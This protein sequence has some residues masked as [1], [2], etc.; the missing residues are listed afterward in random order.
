MEGGL[1]IDFIE[2]EH[3][4]VLLVV[5]VSAAS[6]GSEFSS[7]GVCLVGGMTLPVPPSSDG[8]GLSL[9]V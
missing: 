4:L 9:R 8:P 5:F 2:T 6:D 1:S 3:A 7:S